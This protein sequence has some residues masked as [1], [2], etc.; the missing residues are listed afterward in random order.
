MKQ[1]LASNDFVTL[2]Q[3]N[4]QQLPAVEVFWRIIFVIYKFSPLTVLYLI[5]AFQ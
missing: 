4:I 5:I 2:K 3:Q 1:S